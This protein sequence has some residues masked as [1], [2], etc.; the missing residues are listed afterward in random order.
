M[1]VNMNIE[2]NSYYVAK[3][4][5]K[6][7]GETPKHVFLKLRKRNLTHPQPP[8]SSGKLAGTDFATDVELPPP[9]SPGPLP[10]A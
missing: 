8:K 7:F 3:C 2:S 10:P 6:Y 9:P 4:K 5:Q 1:F